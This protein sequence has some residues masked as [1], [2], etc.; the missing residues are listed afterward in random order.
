MIRKFIIT[1]ML[2]VASALL[3]TSVL[4]LLKPKRIPVSFEQPEITAVEEF[5]HAYF[6]QQ[7]FYTGILS[8]D[9]VDPVTP[10]V[11]GGIVSHHFFVERNIAKLFGSWSGQ[12]FKT[13]VI[14]GPNHFNAGDGDLLTSSEAY[15][16]PWGDLEPNLGVIG[17]LTK[18]GLVKNEEYPFEREHSIS[19][20]VGFIKH[21]FPNAQIVPIIIKHNTTKEKMQALAEQLNQILPSDSLVLASVDFSHHVTNEVAQKQDKQSIALLKTWDLDGIW[22]L[23]TTQMDS[24]PTIYALLKYLELKGAKNMQYWNTNQALVSG[25]LNSTDVTSYIFASFVR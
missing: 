4:F 2:V 6:M 14:I 15:K 7:E 19:V 9:K 22:K 11:Y 18:N 23:P 5:H 24:P 8:L 12:K 13:I 17:R 1:G 10:Q 25:S 21:S 16:T 20:E 3:F